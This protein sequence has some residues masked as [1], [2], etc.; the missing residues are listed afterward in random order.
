[1][2]DSGAA[3]TEATELWAEHRN[4]DPTPFIWTKTADAILT[5]ARRASASPGVPPIPPQWRGPLGG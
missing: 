4:D 3:V 5:K 2:F 1:V